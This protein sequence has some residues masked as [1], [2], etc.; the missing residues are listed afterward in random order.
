MSAQSVPI[1]SWGGWCA[2]VLIYAGVSALA[3]W[4]SPL[5]CAVVAAFMVIDLIHHAAD[6][7]RR[8][9]GYRPIPRHP[10]VS[11]VKSTKLRVTGRALI[12]IFVTVWLICAA[13]GRAALDVSWGEALIQAAA[14]AA[15][16]GIASALMLPV[17]AIG[18]LW[19]LSVTLGLL[20]SLGDLAAMIFAPRTTRQSWHRA[21]DATDHRLADLVLG[22][23]AQVPL[24]ADM[25]ER[26]AIDAK[27]AK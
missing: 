1:P 20:L 7:A 5:L 16:A 12:L 10:A 23:P 26:A 27:G 6:I 17:A 8:R 13:V 15:F 24:R 21:I 3:Y 4:W 22:Q 11:G 9:T 25:A 18:L 19:V 2:R 14:L